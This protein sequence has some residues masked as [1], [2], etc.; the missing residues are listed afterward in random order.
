MIAIWFSPHG[1]QFIDSK[2]TRSFS[3]FA[4]MPSSALQTNVLFDHISHPPDGQA[5]TGNDLKKFRVLLHSSHCYS[6]GPA[7]EICRD[8]S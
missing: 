1:Y 8:F 2:E 3:N 7:M 6:Y 4:L 5:S